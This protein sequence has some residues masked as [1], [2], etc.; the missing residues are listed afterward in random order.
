MAL[1]SRCLRQSKIWGGAKSLDVWLRA[2]RALRGFLKAYAL[3]VYLHRSCC[4]AS[5]L[6]NSPAFREERE[7]AKGEMAKKKMRELGGQ[8][9]KRVRAGR[10]AAGREQWSEGAPPK[11]LPAL[12][13]SSVVLEV[14]VD[15]ENVPGQIPRQKLGASEAKTERLQKKQGS[16]FYP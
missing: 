10:N 16:S 15:L 12:A 2:Q 7:D 13:G 9:V 4:P 6:G 14:R 1:I 8:R 5:R 11:V 3:G